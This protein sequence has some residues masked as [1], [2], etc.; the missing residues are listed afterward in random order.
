MFV[1]PAQEVLTVQSVVY[2]Q[3]A[4]EIERVVRCVNASVAVATRARPGL[5]VSLLLGDCSPTPRLGAEDLARMVR[6]SDRMTPISY[7]H[8]GANL[9][10]GG[11]HAELAA[12]D[13][14]GATT[15]L[16]LN[17]DLVLAPSALQFMFSALT[18][19]VGAVELRQVP[20]EHPKHYDPVTGETEWVTGAGLLLRRDAFIA[21]GGFDH[22]NYPMYADDVDLSWSLRSAGYRLVHEPRAVGFHAKR[23]NEHGGWGA[24]ELEWISG[25]E[26]EVVIR[27]KWG[28]QDAARARLHELLGSVDSRQVTAGRR[29]MERYPDGLPLTRQDGRDVARPE[30]PGY[31]ETRYA[32]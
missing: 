32:L 20:I 11:G 25:Y 13:E 2:Q 18:T 8:F 27:A 15:L 12:S 4:A 16:V 22:V 1:E 21:V 6:V 9:G 19:D 26:A 23:L 29:I 5:K 10:H 17:P 28:S 14:T 31:T 7:R 24:S 30:V 3:T